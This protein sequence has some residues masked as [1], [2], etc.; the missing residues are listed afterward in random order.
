MSSA[1]LPIPPSFV[2]TPGAPSTAGVGLR[3]YQGLQFKLGLLFLVLVIVLGAVAV[4]AGYQLVGRGLNAGNYRYEESVS[5]R[6]VAQIELPVTTAESLAGALAV[7]MQNR[8][9]RPALRAVMQQLSER[10]PNGGL[11]ASIG[12]WPEPGTFE[13]GVERASV[14]LLRDANGHLQ[15]REDYNDPRSIPYFREAWYTPVRYASA[16]RCFWTLNYLDLLAKR[17]VVTCSLSLGGPGNFL[18]VVTVSLD[19]GEL[20]KYFAA[21]TADASGYALLLDRDNRLLALST[22]AQGALGG[23][24]RSRNIA[25]LA[26]RNPAFNPL[27]IALNNQLQKFVD[28]AVHSP[29]YDAAS[30]SALKDATRD[31]SRT[32]AESALATIWNAVDDGSPAQQLQL[33]A[34]AVLHSAG[35]AVLR[36]LPG[37]HWRIASV[38]AAREGE[39]G[40]RYLI[41][42]ALVLTLGA[43]MLTL[44][45]AWGAIRR[46]VVRPLRRMARELATYE[47]SADALGVAL[48]ES[49][50]NEVGLLAHWYNERV[51]QLRGQIESVRITRTQLYA[52]TAERQRVQEAL[53]RVQ[54]RSSLALG[55]IEDGVIATDEKGL[56]EDMNPVA[57]RLI[58]TSLR[59]ARGQAFNKVFSARLDAENATAL[60]DL[61]KLAVERGARIEYTGGVTLLRPRDEQTAIAIVA[62]PL[63]DRTARNLG[64]II[65]FRELA[66]AAALAAPEH[67]QDA[68]DPST[69]LGGRAACERSLRALLAVNADHPNRQALLL[70]DLDAAGAVREHGG[71]AAIDALTQRAAEPMVARGGGSDHVFR[72]SGERFALVLADTDVE[73]SIKFSEALREELAQ[74]AFTW[75]GERF[76]LTSSL[77]ICLGSYMLSP[78][79]DNV[80]EALRRA[81]EAAAAARRRGGNL[82]VAYSPEV[83]LPTRRAEEALWTQRVR[84]GLEDDLFHLTTQW[85][86]PSRRH[87]AEG[88]VFEILLTLEDEEGFWSPAAAFLPAAERGGL[89]SELDRWVLL[90]TL[91]LL[92]AQAEAYHQLAFCSVNLT[93]ASLSDPRLL[94]FLAEQFSKRPDIAVS[95][96]CFELPRDAVA[97][98]AK[99]AQ[100]FCEAMRTFGCRV[101]ADF[102]PG[103]HATELERLRALPID[104]LKLDAR[105][106]PDIAT[107]PLEQV[108]GESAMRVARHLNRRV[109]IT[110]LDRDVWIEAWRKLGAD[111][112]Q[113][114][115]LARPSPIPFAKG[116]TD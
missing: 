94:D 88:Q 13:A 37:T 83:E 4:F 2:S 101:A 67:S 84:R 26:Q 51:M 60:P 96:L 112:F 58:G 63:R 77:G 28:T 6:L 95:K 68:I 114:F 93:E 80:A 46:A 115:S 66:R 65:V 15:A 86:T 53:T 21:S 78:H 35:Y 23:N 18:G 54:E 27:A 113:G 104:F 97:Q 14:Y 109:I 36:T 106:F 72:L 42:Q 59:L 11:I 108:L 31:M 55:S 73:H 98:Q 74:T 19:V 76:H 62:I 102:N 103:R 111:Y 45:F 5:H 33:T 107:D 3:W 82:V 39:E 17:D 69:G 47:S 105:Q 99:H 92:E 100:K 22:Q 24:D 25:E 52:E 75:N 61:A 56:I 50:R 70:V 91:D 29:Q 44:A 81:A 89:S 43:A 34:D 64:C 10:I 20:A 8:L 79:G 16:R 116:L 57:E 30:I 49:S 38:T 48:D 1:R 87:A 12:I 41:S 9:S 40:S 32:E 71:P 85:I 110:G 90:H 7:Q